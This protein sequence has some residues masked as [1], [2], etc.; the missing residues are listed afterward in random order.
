ML[1]MCVNYGYLLY[2]APTTKPPVASWQ[3]MC[4]LVSTIVFLGLL[5]G[6]V[7]GIM[8]AEEANSYK[9]MLLA[10]KGDP[11]AYLIGIVLGFIAGFVNEIMRE[12]GGDLRLQ[13][14]IPL[15]DPYDL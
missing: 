9:M 6:L 3:Q 4:L 15:P 8:D 2:F 14:T 5:Y 12:S 13:D 1:I 10:L 11:Y 7:M